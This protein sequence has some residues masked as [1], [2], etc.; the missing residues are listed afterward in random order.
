MFMMRIFFSFFLV[1]GLAACSSGNTHM[2]AGTHNLS[3]G[4]CRN[5]QVCNGGDCRTYEE[6]MPQ[7]QCEMLG[8]EFTPRDYRRRWLF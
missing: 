3:K 5:I 1:A 4:D 8:G 2:S 7:A 6:L